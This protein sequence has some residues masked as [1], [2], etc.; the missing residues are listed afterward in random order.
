MCLYSGFKFYKC[1]VEMYTSLCRQ[2][3]GQYEYYKNYDDLEVRH[4]TI[5]FPFN[6]REN[7]LVLF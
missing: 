6:L 2:H 7:G 5:A 3:P 4:V 1:N